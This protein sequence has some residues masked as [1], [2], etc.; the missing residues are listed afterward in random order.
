[1]RQIY[2]WLNQSFQNVAQAIFD[3]TDGVVPVPEPPLYHAHSLWY[4]NRMQ[5][6]TC[7]LLFCREPGRDNLAAYLEPVE[8][9]AIFCACSSVQHM[10]YC[11]PIEGYAPYGY[12]QTQH[13]S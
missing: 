7:I 13:W 1:M 6:L 10:Y 11:V 2:A 12:R 5:G 9:H 8:F 4:T 3:I